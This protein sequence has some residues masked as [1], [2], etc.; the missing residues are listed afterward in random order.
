[1]AFR[2]AHLKRQRQILALGGGEPLG[3]AHG[4]LPESALAIR[5]LESALNNLA[6]AASNDTAILQQLTAANLALTSSVATL[7]ATNKNWWRR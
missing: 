2:L 3:G 1:M 5:R 7:T 6:L 4:V